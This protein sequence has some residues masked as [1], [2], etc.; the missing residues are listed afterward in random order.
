MVKLNNGRNF[1]L[2]ACDIARDISF[3]KLQSFWLT[4]ALISSC[5]LCK[6]WSFQASTTEKVSNIQRSQIYAHI[7]QIYAHVGGAVA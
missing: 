2:F 6:I 7:S 5:I 4:S 1:Q 3:R